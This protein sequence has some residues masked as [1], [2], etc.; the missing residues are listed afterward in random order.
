MPAASP[1]KCPKCGMKKSPTAKMCP[2]C[3]KKMKKK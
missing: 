1:T 2:D 3:M